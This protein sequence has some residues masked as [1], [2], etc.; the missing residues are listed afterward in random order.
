MVAGRPTDYNEELTAYICDKISTS[1][2]GLRKLCREDDRLPDPATIYGWCF[3]HEEFNKRYLRA[4]DFQQ[5]RMVEEINEE[6]DKDICYYTDSEG[7][8]RIDS[9]SVALATAKASN[10]KWVASKLAA[11]RF[12]DKAKAEET[13]TLIEKLL[14]KIK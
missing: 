2:D 4:R 13:S 8:K 11:G 12:G 14:E 3:R 6:I 7:N 5:L 1:G 9:P 10:K